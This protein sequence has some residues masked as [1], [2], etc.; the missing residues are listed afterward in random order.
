LKKR[1]RLAL[2]ANQCINAPT[3]HYV[4]IV[5][6]VENFQNG[7]IIVFVASFDHRRKDS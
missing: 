1:K 6:Q 3:M 2:V 4:F 7:F 5:E